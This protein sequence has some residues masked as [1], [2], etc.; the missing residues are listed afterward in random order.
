MSTSRGK[1][2]EQVVRRDLEKLDNVDVIRLYDPVGGYT[3]V[4]NIC[5]FIVYKY[6]HMLCLECKT[7]Q[8]NT[9]H[10]SMISQYNSLIDQLNFN[11]VKPGVLIWYINQKE[12]WWVGA[13]YMK[14]QHE[15]LGKKSINIKDLR[16]ART[17]SV[18]KIDTTV[19]RINPVCDFTSLF[20]QL[21]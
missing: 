2:F 4:K 21:D 3:G 10:Y 8:E 15:D 11:G 20:N 16:D 7:T 13:D 9:L 5:D 12:V 18:V 6:P 14:I 1:D 17:T 19:K